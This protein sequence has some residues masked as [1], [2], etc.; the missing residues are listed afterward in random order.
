MLS[1]G[2][3]LAGS[4]RLGVEACNMSCPPPGL[5]GE[6]A[7]ALSGEGQPTECA[8]RRGRYYRGLARRS[9]RPVLAAC[10]HHDILCWHLESSAKER[11]EWLDG[12]Y[13]RKRREMLRRRTVPRSF[14]S[15]EAFHFRNFHKCSFSLSLCHDF[16]FWFSS[17][18]IEKKCSK[19]TL[20]TQF[21]IF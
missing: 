6:G 13:K 5:L 4:S 18:H 10:V 1:E 12:E 19:Y 3:Q 20:F 21:L 2:G 15:L 16:Q 9:V 11:V 17:W 14:R 8:L 7:P